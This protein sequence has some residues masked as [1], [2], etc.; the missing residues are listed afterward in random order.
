MKT[1]R[2]RVFLTSEF[3]DL[4]EDT[5]TRKAL[6]RLVQE[7][8]LERVAQGVY[9]YPETDPDFGVLHPSAEEVVEHIVRRDRIRIIPTEAA[10]LSYVGLSTQVP[11]NLVYLTDGGSRKLKIG[12]QIVKFKATTPKRV[13][14]KSRVTMLVVQALRDIG[15]G[16]V[17]DKHLRHVKALLQ[18]EDAKIVR[19]DLQLAPAWIARLLK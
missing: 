2:G 17:T 5:A 7:G 6:S 8:V 19:H 10:A 3:S 18:N 15:K 11:V 12:K 1:K 4:G 9:V 16:R 14:F 13:A